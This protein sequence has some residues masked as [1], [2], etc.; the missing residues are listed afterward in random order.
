MAVLRFRT[1]YR[2]QIISGEKTQTLRAKVPGGVRVGVVVQA[3]SS[4]SEP[5]WGS[6]RID[7]ITSVNVSEITD[8]TARLDGFADARSLRGELAR[9]YPGVRELYAIRFTCVDW[10]AAFEPP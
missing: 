1:V 3:A 10:D 2:A 4:Y 8:S 7:S 6:L 9:L 5:P